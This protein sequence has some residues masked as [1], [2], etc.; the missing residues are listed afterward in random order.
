MPYPADRTNE[1]GADRSRRRAA[2]LAAD[3]V[4]VIF[5]RTRSNYEPGMVT[6]REDGT[7]T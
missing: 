6:E 1:S 3:G 4:L 7:C 2:C 5:T